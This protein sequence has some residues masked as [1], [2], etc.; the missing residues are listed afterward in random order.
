MNPSQ[1]GSVAHPKIA[2]SHLQRLAYIY[3]RQSSNKQVAQ[4]KE[5]QQYQ[6]QLQHRAQALGW[7]AERI[8]VID[9]DQGVSGKEAAGRSG[10]QELVAEVSLGRV[11]IVF[12]YE[13][14]RLARNN[15]DW[16]IL[17]DLSA[18]FGTLIADDDGVYDARQYNDRLLL[19]LKG[20]ISEA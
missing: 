3:V 2:V 1:N 10:F 5:S 9:S 19:G 16:Y 20:T 7:T 18:V 14:S 8:R 15:R 17:L 12:G 11:G 4:N 13:V 6:Y